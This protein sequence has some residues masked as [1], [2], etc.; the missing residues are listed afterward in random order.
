MSGNMSSPPA[1]WQIADNAQLKFRFWDDE[2]VLYHGAS[3]D[4][5]R[6]PELVGRL[7]QQLLQAPATTAA[8]AESINLH[9]EDV[10][11]ALRQMSQLG[12]TVVR[13]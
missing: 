8:L 9:E 10:N 13:A 2:C 6:L 3:G 11:S 7:L 5:H 4:T 1:L 12:I